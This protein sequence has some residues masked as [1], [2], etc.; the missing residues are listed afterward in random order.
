MDPGLAKSAIEQHKAMQKQTGLVSSESSQPFS[1]LPQQ[2]WIQARKLLH[3][4]VNRV[5]KLTLTICGLTIN[6]TEIPYKYKLGSASNNLVCTIALV[7]KQVSKLIP[8]K[9]DRQ[10]W[11]QEEFELTLSE[12]PN[13]QNATVRRI[14]KNPRC[15][16]Q[17]VKHHP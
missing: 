13:I 2:Q 12:L 15:R 3:E 9:K 11:T 14:K 5:A 17:K 4:D 7:N 1:V 8:D 16:S 6:G 10:S